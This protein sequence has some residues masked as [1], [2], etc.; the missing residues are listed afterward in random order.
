MKVLHSLTSLKDEC[1]FSAAGPGTE[2][3]S[4]GTKLLPHF[5]LENGGH[6]SMQ[7]VAFLKPNKQ[8]VNTFALLFSISA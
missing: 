5:I 8:T 3:A 4:S 7:L 2:P 1:S 6:F